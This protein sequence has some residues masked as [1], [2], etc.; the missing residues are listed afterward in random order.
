MNLP[1]RLIKSRHG[2]FYYRIQYLAP[3][4]RKEHRISL[5]TKSPTVAKYKATLISATILQLRSSVAD[6]TKP[7]DPNDPSTW[8][9]ILDGSTPIRKLDLEFPGGFAIRNI[10]TETDMDRARELLSDLKARRL[11]NAAVTAQVL[12]QSPPE[13][14]PA[15]NQTTVRVPARRLRSM[16]LDALIRRYA[17]RK[18]SQLAHK[19]LYE[20]G[21]NQRKFAKWIAAQTKNKNYPVHEIT[22]GD[23]ADYIDDLKATKISDNT[24]QQ[25][26]LA[27]ISNLFE[28]AQSLGV[29]PDEDLPTRG[30]R[31][32]TK[33]DKNK[34]EDSKSD[35]TYT[36]EELA[37]I[38]NPKTF[39]EREKPDDYWVPLLALF[40]GARISELCQL[41]ISDIYQFGGLWVMSINNYQNN[42]LKTPTSR[43]IIPIHLQLIQLGLLDYVDD[44]KEF[45]GRLFPY[46][47][48]APGGNRSATSSERFS[49]YRHEIGISDPQ[50][51]FHSFRATVNDSLKQQGVAEESRCQFV[52]HK[53]ET[54]NSSVYANPHHM[55]FL[56]TNVVSKL[57]YQSVPFVELT[58][59]KG[60][61]NEKLKRLCEIK[62]QRIAHNESKKKL[63]PE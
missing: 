28:F 3:S 61:F 2:V 1:S 48:P 21:N 38:F 42:H 9:S 40:T 52:G 57:N 49:K 29:Y 23:I 35:K 8:D 36:D 59:K 18:K 53:H 4:G 45:G 46:L 37:M 39:L 15:T 17:I 41:S 58:Y 24:I 13:I 60:R 5:Q 43:R 44:V 32:F 56:M 31:V 33:K 10:N 27:P 50:K 47:T 34:L 25:K 63:T 62:R 7:F 6:M 14:R 54:I 19:T 51:V 12:P 55:Q 30:H 26:Y 22:K 16:D 11:I 20:Y